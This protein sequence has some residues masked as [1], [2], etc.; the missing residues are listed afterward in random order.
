MS[1]AFALFGSTVVLA[2]STGATASRS[3]DAVGTRP[4]RQIR[5]L[6]GGYRPVTI[7]GAWS[8]G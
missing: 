1:K 8:S 4:V 3:H 7:E 6:S 5:P 2:G